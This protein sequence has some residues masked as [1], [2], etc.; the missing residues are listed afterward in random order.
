[1]T[2]IAYRI[3]WITPPLRV[4][5]PFGLYPQVQIE[6]NG[7]P[8]IYPHGAILSILQ[9]YHILIGPLLFYTP[10]SKIGNVEPPVFTPWGCNPINAVL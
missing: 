7:S 5:T 1:M 3:N 8:G 2:V 4:T 6:K 9:L 10:M